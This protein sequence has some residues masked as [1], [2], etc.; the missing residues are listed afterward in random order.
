MKY[1][2]LIFL[3][4]QSVFGLSIN[5]SLLKIHAV[6]VPK[7]Y[8]MDYDFK[9]K[10]KN[11]SITI[12]ILYDSNS[13]KSAVLLKNKIEAKYHQKIENYTIKT[14]LLPYR[15]VTNSYANLYY[16][17]PTNTKNIKRVIKQAQ[18]VKALTFSYSKNDLKDGIM[19][20]LEVGKKVKPIINLNAVKTHNIT[21]RPILLKISNIY[22]KNY[23][24]I[25][26]F[27]NIYYSYIPSIEYQS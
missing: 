11:N 13:Y 25:F 23:N 7:I 24:S 27:E 6:L 10:L 17:F 14:I 15:K 26:Y 18:R 19:L 1:I 2:L 20:S 12:T 22:T 21:F 9:E 3:L 8:L 5:E 4:I 16:L